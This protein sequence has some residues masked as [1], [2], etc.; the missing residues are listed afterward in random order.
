MTPGP[1]SLSLEVPTKLGA[2]FM[3]DDDVPS[4]FVPVY[5]VRLQPLDSVHLRYVPA[6]E[7]PVQIVLTMQD[8]Q[9]LTRAHQI[10]PQGAILEVDMKMEV[11]AEIYRQIGKLARTMDW[12]LPPED[13]SPA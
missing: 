12:P 4:G 1:P 13:E 10:N 7:S 2:K 9:G 5:R 3:S 8:H 11:A 6:A